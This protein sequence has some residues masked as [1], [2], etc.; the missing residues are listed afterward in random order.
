MQ[1]THYL[2]LAA[3]TFCD[4]RS[5]LRPQRLP[6]FP[7]ACTFDQGEEKMQQTTYRGYS[8]RFHRTDRYWSAQIRKPGGFV[9]LRDGYI[10]A[11]HEEGAPVLLTRACARIDAEL[12]QRLTKSKPTP[13]GR[14]LSDNDVAFIRRQIE[15]LE[16]VEVSEEMRALIAGQW[17][18]LLAKIWP[19]KPN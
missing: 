5:A 9:I 8:I 14:E 19:A 4:G 16:A 10:T 1:R 3:S 6:L 12:A 17:P 11:T 2:N 18:E 13:N 15:K 7:A